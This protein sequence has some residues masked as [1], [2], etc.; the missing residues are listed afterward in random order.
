M[1][2]LN[3]YLYFSGNTEDAF[4]F[5]KTVFDAEIAMVMR[6]NEAPENV[7]P[8]SQGE[9]EGNLIMHISL[10]IGKTSVLMGSDKPPSSGPTEIGDNIN[11]SI[12]AESIDEGTRIFERLSKGGQVT[13]PFG[14]AFWGSYFG[15]LTDRFGVMW[16]VSC[17]RPATS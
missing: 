17:D 12:S 11:I 6:F 2:A 16:M 14:P 10:P 15:M 13:M 4:N 7:M 8:A 9:D 1:A 3:P 5:Y